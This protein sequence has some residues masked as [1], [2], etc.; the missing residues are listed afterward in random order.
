[1]RDAPRR[2]ACPNSDD[3]DED[4]DVRLCVPATPVDSPLF[5]TPGIFID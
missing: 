2:A 3:D 1:M 4:A 5:A